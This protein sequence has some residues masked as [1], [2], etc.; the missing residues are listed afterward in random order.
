MPFRT[1]KVYGWVVAVGAVSGGVIG[2]IIGSVG[3]IG[4]KGDF[5]TSKEWWGKFIFGLE[6]TQPFKI[7]VDLIRNNI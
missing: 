2:G 5:L 1:G 4:T 3:N 6:F 7:G